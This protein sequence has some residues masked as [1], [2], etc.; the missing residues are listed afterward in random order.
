MCAIEMITTL[1]KLLLLVSFMFVFSGVHAQYTSTKTPL[2]DMVNAIKND[3]VTD[4]FK[5]F[6]NFVP[7]TIN[8]AQSVYS[9]N[10]AE[11][12]LKDFFDKNIAKE[13]DVTDNGSPD[14]TSKFIIGSL[15]TTN[16]FKYNVY[17]LIKLKDG[18]YILQDFRLNKE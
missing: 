10:Q 5:Y 15:T 18:N 8:N 11:V 16:S 1:K 17:I 3:R 14:N 12:V 4:L 2:E 13:F 6:D 7:L 9:R